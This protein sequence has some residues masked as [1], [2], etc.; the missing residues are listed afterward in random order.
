MIYDLKTTFADGIALP[1]AITAGTVLGNPIDM[2]TM[3]PGVTPAQNV[4]PQYP[5]GNPLGSPGLQLRNLGPGEPMYLIIRLRNVANGNV[6]VGASGTFQIALVTADNAALTT[7][8]AQIVATATYANQTLV[9]GTILL[10]VPLPI[11]NLR[12]FIG[13]KEVVGT[14]VLTSA[15]SPIL[16]AFLAHDAAFWQAYAQPQLS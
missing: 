2:S 8:A 12:E 15:G 6:I 4:N 3:Q 10:A 9:P 5:L 14:A 7:N 13:L 1:T 16:D 11:A